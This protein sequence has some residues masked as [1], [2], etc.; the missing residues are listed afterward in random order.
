[1]LRR[2]FGDSAMAR[3]PSGG[4]GLL[5]WLAPVAIFVLGVGTVLW[6]RRRRDDAVPRVVVADDKLRELRDEVRRDI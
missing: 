5:V 2:D 4:S 6:V 1:M 3:P